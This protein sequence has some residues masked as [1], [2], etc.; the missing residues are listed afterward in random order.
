M[1]VL[2]FKMLYWSIRRAES[3]SFFSSMSLSSAV[4]CNL[5]ICLILILLIWIQLMVLYN[6][7]FFRLNQQLAWCPPIF[8]SIWFLFHRIASNKESHSRLYQV[9]YEVFFSCFES[10]LMMISTSFHVSLTDSRGRRKG[11]KMNKIWNFVWIYCYSIGHSFT[12]ERCEFNEVH[13]LELLA[14]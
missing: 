2:G 12:A 3:F 6:L 1:Y 10:R 9:N 13:L 7:L 4:T 8:F 14:V 11:R 5:M